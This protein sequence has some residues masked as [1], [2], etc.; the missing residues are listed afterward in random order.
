MAS[1]PATESSDEIEDDPERLGPWERIRASI[2]L[3]LAQEFG[4]EVEEE[5]ENEDGE[6]QRESERRPIDEHQQNDVVEG[7]RGLSFTSQ[8][9]KV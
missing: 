8:S 9:R 7:W 3:R 5:E 4:D 6:E 1:L 2:G